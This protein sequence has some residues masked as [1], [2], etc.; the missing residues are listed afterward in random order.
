MFQVC[1]VME[2]KGRHDLVE[3]LK[4]EDEMDRI[5]D[6]IDFLQPLDGTGEVPSSG[7]ETP[8]RHF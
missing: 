8:R 7:Y 4:D 1:A 3:L 6:T 2:V 5:Q